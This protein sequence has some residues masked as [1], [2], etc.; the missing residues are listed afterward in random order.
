MSGF[1]FLFSR[2]SQTMPIVLLCMMGVLFFSCSQDVQRESFVA[3]LERIDGYIAGGGNTVAHSALKDLTKIAS[4]G[5]QR[6]SIVK[7]YVRMGYLAE[8]E[9]DLVEIRERFPENDDIETV[10]IYVLLR[11][12]RAE[13]AAVL[14]EPLR[15]TSRGG[16]WAEALLASGAPGSKAVLGTDVSPV[17]LAAWKAT[18]NPL[19]LQNAAV[20]QMLNG[21]GSEA[22]KLHPAVFVPE[23][24]PLFWA[25]LSYDTGGY[26]QAYEDALAVRGNSE[27]VEAELLAEESVPIEA[28]LL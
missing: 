1:G 7:R 2:F 27:E 6:L 3:S 10:Y 13:E 14:A 19:F 12:G 17:F 8:A 26:F 4:G 22:R 9:K 18:A 23:D 5:D 28:L 11:Q 20:V 15:N 21:K 16:L 25:Y 24:N